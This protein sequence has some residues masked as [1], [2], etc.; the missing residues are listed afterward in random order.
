M[1]SAKFDY[2]VAKT[3]ADAVASLAA[4]KSAAVIAGG[5]SLVPMLNLRVVL[6]DLLVNISRIGELKET[7][8]TRAAMRIGALTTHAD[9]EDGKIPD[10]FGGLLRKVAAGIS[11]RAIRHYGTI[12]GSLAL[13]D[14]AADWPVCLMALDASV[15]IADGKN[16]RAD[17][18][19]SFIQGQYSTSLGNNE[20]VVAIDIPRPA[21]PLRWGLA[22]VARKSGAFAESFAVAVDR[23]GTGG[24]A[25]ALGGAVTHPFLLTTAAK[26]LDGPNSAASEETLRAAIMQDV[27][28]HLPQADPYLMRLHTATVLRAVR[29]MRSR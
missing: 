14:P 16:V 20:I 17:P 22:K 5:Q 7:G 24:V 23:A 21:A 9:I 29:E 28:G 1:K 25:I 15:Q 11:Y 18:V 13:A 26:Q 10:W 3:V 4:E 19:S 6:P 27:Q 2:V 12:G 8:E